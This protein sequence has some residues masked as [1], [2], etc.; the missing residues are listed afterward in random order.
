MK[1]KINNFLLVANYASDYGYAWWLME[2][3]WIEVANLINSNKSKAYLIY[4]KI[5]TISEAIKKSKIIVCE[6]AF[7]F[8]KAEQRRAI[9]LFLKKNSIKYIYLTD[10]S[11][12]SI[13][14]FYLRCWGVKKIII[15]DH[16]PGE[17]SRPNFFKGII[18]RFIH[19]LKIFSA[20]Q[21]IGVSKF[22]YDR[23]LKIGCIP[24][25]RCSYVLNGINPFKKC[26]RIL[27]YAIKQFNLP[28]DALLVVSTGRATFY[29]GL[30]FII[31][32][33]EELIKTHKI[34]TLYFIHCGDGVDL[35]HFRMII[36]E[37]QLE[38][39]FILAGMRKDIKE[40]LLSCNI[41]IHASL[42]EAFSLSILEYMSAGLACIIPD[43]CGNKEAV[44]HDY[45]G[46]IYQTRNKKE[47]IEFVIKLVNDKKYRD[48]LGANAAYTVDKLFNIERANKEL[49]KIISTVFRN[50]D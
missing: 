47:V 26:D 5:T 40:I 7:K 35:I 24:K 32:C 2:N 41:G 28:N 45:N 6:L 38:D 37:K 21:Y 33:A 8:E 22:V 43:N 31:E 14:Y 1:E 20:D 44:I 48:K 49:L 23:F 17:R 42:G 10:K 39:R 19:E 4:P 30:D 50:R 9:K 46:L 25:Q 13:N 12:F 11:Y 18:K 3:Y 16:S 29:K 27:N 15:H 36:K 34:E